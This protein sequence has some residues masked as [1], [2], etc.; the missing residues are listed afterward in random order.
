MLG[1]LLACLVTPGCR[2]SA[3][4]PAAPR[5]LLLVVVDTLRADHLGA[6]GYS[7]ATSPH[8]DT[9][10]RINLAAEYP[11]VLERLGSVIGDHHARG[12]RLD[13]EQRERQFK[14][15]FEALKA[16]GQAQQEWG[17]WDGVLLDGASAVDAS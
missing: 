8:I 4:A 14:E 16:L 12:L 10:E 11:E 7:L 9:L 6:Y 3:A 13:A 1:A 15:G 2:P 5:H 17:D